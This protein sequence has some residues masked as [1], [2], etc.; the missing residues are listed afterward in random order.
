MRVVENGAARLSRVVQ[1]GLLT[2]GQFDHLL[3][4]DESTLTVSNL[5]LSHDLYPFTVIPLG[6]VNRNCVTRNCVTKRIV[7]LG[8]IANRYEHRVFSAGLN[9]LLP[10]TISVDW[11]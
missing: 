5:V 1:N 6:I 9:T 11:C 10:T 2:R 3:S 8:E 7:Y 4:G